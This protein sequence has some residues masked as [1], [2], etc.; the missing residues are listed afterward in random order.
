MAM[1]LRKI[2]ENDMAWACGIHRGDE[3][4]IQVFLKRIKE[5]AA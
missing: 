5:R 1:G 4:G 2:M 3:K